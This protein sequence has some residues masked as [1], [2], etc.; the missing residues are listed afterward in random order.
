MYDVIAVLGII[1]I[2]GILFSM[3]IMM[4]KWTLEEGKKQNE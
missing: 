3:V 4:L 1:A 2:W